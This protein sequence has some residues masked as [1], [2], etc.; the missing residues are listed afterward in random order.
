[1]SL[2]IRSPQSVGIIGLGYVGL[3]VI[4]LEASAAGVS[5]VATAVGGIP[6]VIVD[7]K[8]GFLVASGDSVALA[9]RIIELLLN[10]ATRLAMG[11]AARER[12]RQEFSFEKMSRQ[13]FELFQAHLACP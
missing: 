6:E 5:T 11:Q 7:G 12:S 3:P 2:S 1:M 4:L 9:Q 8:S 13:Y 10:D